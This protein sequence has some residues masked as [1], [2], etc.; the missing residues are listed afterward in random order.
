MSAASIALV[1]AAI[2]RSSRSGCSGSS[3]L[4]IDPHDLL[5]GADHAQ[6]S[7][8]LAVVDEHHARTDRCRR[9]PSATRTAADARSSVPTTPTSE[10]WMSSVARFVATFALPPATARSLVTSSTGTGASGEIRL[11]LAFDIAVEHH[12]AD[13]RDAA[14][15]EQVEIA[16]HG[17]YRVS[18]MQGEGVRRRVRARPPRSANRSNRASSRDDEHGRHGSARRVG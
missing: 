18:N 11:T 9:R 15:G 10:T 5:L 1:A 7:D 14:G 6:L 4:L 13:H 2:S 3:V 17:P 12:V 16:G 8:R